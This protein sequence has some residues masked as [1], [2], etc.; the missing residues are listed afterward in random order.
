MSLNTV[1]KQAKK[2]SNPYLRFK[3]YVVK[4]ISSQ[5]SWVEQAYFFI[6]IL[7]VKYL[8]ITKGGYVCKDT[9]VLLQ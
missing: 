1:P 7:I 2:F 4:I 9:V 6:S 3:A 5:S 8:P